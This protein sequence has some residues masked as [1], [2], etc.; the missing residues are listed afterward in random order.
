M[1]EQVVTQVPEH[2]LSVPAAGLRRSPLAHLA[3]AMRSASMAGTAVA[4]REI[5]FLTMAGLRVRPGS[6]AAGALDTAAGV[7]L[8]TRCG[9]VG[10]SPDGTAILWQGPDEFLLIAPDGSDAVERLTRALGAEAGAVVDLSANRTTLELAGPAARAVL[11]KGCALDLHPRAFTA[12][13]AVS[14]RLGPVPVVLWQVDRECYRIL[15]RASFADYTAR[16]LLDA[17][18]EFTAPGPAAPQG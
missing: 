15:P 18:A 9:E 2:V 13:M 14:T 4:L 3:A 16:W 5:S 10:G 1:V 11:Q 17:M 8:P 12:G 6:P 7:S